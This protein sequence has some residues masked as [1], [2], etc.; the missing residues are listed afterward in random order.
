M[1]DPADVGRVS[2]QLRLGFPAASDSR[3]PL[4][5][6]GSYAPVVSLLR[7]WRD[8]PA[9]SL[10]LYGPIGSGKS[11]LL[12]AW[13]DW[14]GAALVSAETFAATPLEKVV[15][16]AGAAL[17]V[18]DVQQIEDGPR[19]LAAL[20]LAKSA[21]VTLL[22]AGEGPPALWV[23]GPGDLVSRLAATPAVQIADPDDDATALRL[24]HGCRR[25]FMRLPPETARYLAER[26]PRRWSVIEDT[27]ELLEAFDGPLGKS[28]VGRAIGFGSDE[29][30][31]EEAAF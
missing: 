9:G 19:F 4:I 11:R 25:R 15:S 28:A 1:S 7:R 5:E 29:V 21:G 2:E 20:N 14:T 6:S 10:A 18:D 3:L 16:L 31:D 27:C 17:A 22:M 8:W 24:I 12:S 23:Q 26:L 30:D 13:A